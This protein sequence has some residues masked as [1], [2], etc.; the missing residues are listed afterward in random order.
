MSMKSKLL[1]ILVSITVITGCAIMSGCNAQP[2]NASTADG[3]VQVVDEYDNALV[4]K[5]LRSTLEE[6]E[7]KSI[8][9]IRIDDMIKSDDARERQVYQEVLEE[10]TKIEELQV[11]EADT[12]D[13]DK[14]LK[15]KGVDPLRGLS[16]DASINLSVFLK[17]DAII[18]G[19]IESED[20]DINLKV[21]NAMDGGV[22][23]S[24]TLSNLQIPIGKASTKFEIPPELLDSVP[25]PE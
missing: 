20:F 6:L 18:Y 1:T 24:Q 19:T 2:S 4:F 7:I 9:I 15:E 11:V 3:K 22:L 23:F 25:K 17:V 16:T 12:N 14:F 10:L 13:I 5:S 8:S 21:Y